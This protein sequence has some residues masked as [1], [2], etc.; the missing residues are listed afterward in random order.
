MKIYKFDGDDRLSKE[1]HLKHSSGYFDNPDYQTCY[2]YWRQL[3]GERWAPAWKEWQWSEIPAEL[4]PYFAVVNVSYHPL[5]FMYRF[6]GTANAR[7]HGIE[8]T[9]KTTA[10]IRSPVTAKSTLD[11]YRQ[12]AERAAV[13]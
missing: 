1:D 12:V 8:M 3:K 2:A 9:D 11:Q 13:L 10:D 7:M 6:W 4:I 5:E